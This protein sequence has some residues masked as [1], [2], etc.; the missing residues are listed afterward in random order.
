M[1][2]LDYVKQY[3]PQNQ[4]QILINSYKQIEYSWNKVIDLSEIKKGKIENIII[5]G[6]GGSAISGDLMSNFSQKDLRISSLVNRNYNIPP[7]ADDK[8]LVI[9]SS[10]SGNTEETLSATDEAVKKK[11]KIICI[12]TGGKLAELALKNKLPT[13]ILQKGYQP[14]FALWL[15]FFALLKILQILNFIPKEDNIVKD[16]ISLLKKRGEEL[17]KDENEAFKIA[18]SLIGFIPVIY[19]VDDYTSA[20]GVRYKCQFNENSK[21]HAFYSLLPELNHNEIIGWETYHEKIFNTKV[22]NIFDEAYHQRIKKRIKIT[23][24]L[25]E[26]AGCEIIKIESKQKYFKLRLIDIIYFGDWISYYLA[27]LRKQDPS[28]IKNIN[29]L[30]E[31]LVE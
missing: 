4:F 24:E 28:A 15:N 7:Y 9:S 19:A 10:Y 23:S 17:S 12:T 26:K 1:K 13:F 29:Y 22:I 5:T 3:D 2:I 20:V 11:C 31:K 18:E 6:L 21:I 14:R 27:V 8:T 30:K 25:I 16:A